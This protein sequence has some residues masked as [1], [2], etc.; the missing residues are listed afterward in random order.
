M[1]RTGRVEEADVADGP[2]VSDQAGTAPPAARSGTIDALSQRLELESLLTSLTTLFLERPAHEVE[3]AIVMLADSVEASVRTLEEPTH[4]RLHD[5]VQKIIQDKMN[6]GQF[7]DV[8]LTLADIDKISES[9]VTTLMGV[10]HS[11]IKYPEASE[12]AAPASDAAE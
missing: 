10:Y 8:P 11:R 9:F 5:Q 2:M 6:D 12:E 4:Q 3:A 1:L 7:S